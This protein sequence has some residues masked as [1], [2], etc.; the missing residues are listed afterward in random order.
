VL[1]KL[2]SCLS[3]DTGRAAFEETWGD[4]ESALGALIEVSAAWNAYGF[5][6][7]SAVCRVGAT[8][9]LDDLDAVERSMPS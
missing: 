9:F 8:P 2:R 7:E 6:L 5:L 1:R 4:P 3:Y